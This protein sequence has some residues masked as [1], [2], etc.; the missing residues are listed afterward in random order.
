M[1]FPV[2]KNGIVV[3]LGLHFND[4]LVR[5]GPAGNGAGILAERMI[6]IEVT[7]LAKQMFDEFFKGREGT[8]SIRIFL[9]EGG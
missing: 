5:A 2:D 7:D 4:R 1:N 9:N 8:K 3:T 6:M